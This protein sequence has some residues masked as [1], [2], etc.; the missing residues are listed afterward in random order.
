MNTAIR[1]ARP[2]AEKLV[3][4]DNLCWYCYVTN[5]FIRHRQIQIVTWK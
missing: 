4:L 1:F 3:M 5:I 2:P